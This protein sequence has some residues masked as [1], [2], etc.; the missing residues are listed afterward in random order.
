MITQIYAFTRV[1]EIRQAVSAGLDQL[2]FVVGAYGLVHAELDFD[3][4]ASL[5]REV[6]PPAKS[7]A[8]TMSTDTDEILR[9]S[10][11][12]HPDI[13]HISTETDAIGIEQMAEL[14]RKLD[15]KIKLMKAIGVIDQ[16]SIDDAVRFSPVSDI[17]LLDTKIKQ[18]PGIGATGIIHDWYISREIVLRCPV[19]VILAGGLSPENVAEAIQSVHPWGVDS[20]TATNLI[21]SHFL[22]DSDR[23][24]AF[25]EA[26]HS[27]QNGDRI[28][29]V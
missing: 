26:V 10:D 11:A 23:I 8:L 25:V 24:R 7:V 4:A 1:N 5:I 18:L 21:G 19:P 12:V 6:T 2:G 29:S 15:P 9:M 3:T 14:R 17:L 22:K 16:T 28:E 20:N 13:I 27:V